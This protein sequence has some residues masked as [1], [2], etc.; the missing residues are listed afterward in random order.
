M[1]ACNGLNEK[2]V[3]YLWSMRSSGYVVCQDDLSR[4]E[5]HDENLNV[6]IQWIKQSMCHLF[7][8]NACQQGLEAKV[9][10]VLWV[11]KMT[12]EESDDQFTP[13]LCGQCGQE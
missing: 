11:A 9:Y 1:W 13:W 3:I 12:I 2:Y 7:V 5:A 10:Q 6:G 8:V 4:C